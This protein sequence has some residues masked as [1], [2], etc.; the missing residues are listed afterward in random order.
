MAVPYKHKCIADD[1]TSDDFA[2][3]KDVHAFVKSYFWDDSYFS[4]TRETLEN[5]SLEHY[6][7]HFLNWILK[8]SALREMLK[9]QWLFD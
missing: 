7:I 3:L 1:L 4:F 2:E 5:R 9:K 6:H 8:W